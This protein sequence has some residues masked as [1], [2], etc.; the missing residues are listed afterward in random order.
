M[1]ASQLSRNALSGPLAALINL[2]VLAFA[3][4]FYLRYLG[5]EAYGVWLILAAV[6]NAARLGNLGISTAVMKLVSQEHGRGDLQAMQ[7]YTSGATVILLVSGLT[8]FVVIYAFRDGLVAILGVTGDNARK[9]VSLLPLIGGLSAYVLVVQAINA[10]LSGLGRMDIANYVRVGGRILGVGAAAGLLCT[11]RGIESLFVGDILMYA[12]IHV[13]SLLAI[14]RIAHVRFFRLGCV[15]R[16]CCARLLRFGGGV[17]GGSVMDLLLSPFH[18]L[19]L[20]RYAGVA[21]VPVY[22]IAFGA[23]MQIRALLET[24]LR[25]LTP[26]VG[27]IAGQAG[28]DMHTRIRRINRWAMKLVCVVGVP[29][30]AGIFL[31]ARPVLMFWLG[32][33][34]VA[35]LPG[36]LRMMLVATFVSLL[37]ASSY[38]VLLGLGRVRQTFLAHVLVSGLSAAILLVAVL[39]S[40]ITVRTVAQAFILGTVASTAYL[41]WQRDRTVSALE[42]SDAQS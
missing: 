28:E 31:L 29:V 11:G 27:R 14:R 8:V 35:E 41:W 39:C 10:T 34:F 24:G 13:M 3:Y 23:S 12:F 32:N 19:M 25:L 5:Y 30:F 26:E 21:V 37:G 1:L 6:L 38:Y 20:A 18:K 15:D 42:R 17:M 36:V 4:P 40:N 9:I 22:E 2:A 16:Q 7:Q 33:Q